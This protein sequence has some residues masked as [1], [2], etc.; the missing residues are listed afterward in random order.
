M[1]KKIRRIC[2]MS[3]LAVLLLAGCGNKEKKNN[4]NYNSDNYL[5]GLHY[6]VME[7]ADY[8]PIYLELDADAA[9]AT[10][11]NFVNLVNEGFY[12]GLTFH[13]IIEGFMMQGGDPKADG[14]GGSTYTVPGEFSANDYINV[15]THTRGTISMARLGEDYDSA[16]SQFFIMHQDNVDLDYYY[17]AFGRVISGMEIV[18]AICN[19]TPVQDANGTVLKENQPVI[20]CLLIINKDEAVFDDP[21]KETPVS[22]DTSEKLPKPTVSLALSKVDPTSIAGITF[23]DTWVINE[24]G[25]S[26][27]LTA[28]EELLRVALYRTDSAASLTYKEADLLASSSDLPANAVLSVKLTVTNEDFPSLLLV[29]EE[30]NGA[31]ARYLVGYDANGESAYLIPISE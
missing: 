24:D 17:A 10:V 18:D 11:T 8:G 6:A 1:N 16:T 19:D 14:T 31:V 28:T 21:Q 25:T 30:H 5:S 15:L 22:D 23:N 26:Y 27:L 20:D 13:R 3:L 29:A 7:I 4:P 2:L 9:P 12:D